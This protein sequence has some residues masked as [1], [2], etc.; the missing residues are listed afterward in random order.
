MAHL[1]VVGSEP[2]GDA[3]A[4]LQRI[5]AKDLTGGLRALDCLHRYEARIV[6]CDDKWFIVAESFDACSRCTNRERHL[7]L[8]S[9]EV[10]TCGKPCG[11]APK[12]NYVIGQDE[13]LDG[14]LL[15]LGVF[16]VEP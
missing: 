5:A 14:V 1:T 11:E 10:C 4:E 2:P 7:I 3:K 12:R 6:G 15:E 16:Q 9:T 8:V 13:L